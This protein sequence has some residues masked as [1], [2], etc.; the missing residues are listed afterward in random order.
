MTAPPAGIPVTVLRQ[1]CLSLQQT[2]CLLLSLLPVSNLC[3]IVCKQSSR[4][5]V[6]CVCIMTY[7]TSSQWCSKLLNEVLGTA[8]AWGNQENWVTDNSWWCS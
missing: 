6:Q 2:D 7:N 4:H 3:A 8:A 1:A 5:D